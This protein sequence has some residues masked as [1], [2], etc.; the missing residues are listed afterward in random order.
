MSENPSQSFTLPPPADDWLL[1]LSDEPPCGP[2]LEFEPDFLELEQAVAGKPETQFA[3][4]KPP[5]WASARDLA[6]GLFA[7]TRDLRVALWWARAKVNL[8]G[9]ASVPVALAL[10]HGLL[11][12][13][14]DQVHPMPDPDDH[15]FHAR[16]SVLGGLDKL[17]SLLGDIRSATL[18]GERLL[19][20]LRVRDVEVALDK[21]APRPG[22]AARSQSQVRGVLAA[23]PELA[24]PLRTQT[25]AAL[26]SLEQIRSTMASRL[27]ADMGLDLKV[28]TSML[29][30]VAAVL[31]ERADVPAASEGSDGLSVEAP[32]LPQARHS[33]GVHSIENRQDA[34]RAIELVCA[35]LE[36]NEPTNPAQLLLRRASRVID[37][38]FLQLVRDL[39]PD[40]VKD[41][42]RILGVDPAEI[43]DQN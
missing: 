3:A 23:E 29:N 24:D 17:D 40:A 7:R 22:E 13:F 33:T 35:Y 10:L 19:D 39:A 11:D 1:P 16:M 21:L 8:D 4:A 36:R 12:R 25:E 14:W 2:N 41:V 18:C 37:K 31:P 9:F 20:G 15:D 38:N 27:S 5:D 34:V 42:A 43:G 30:C 26:A 6:E 32:K 28:L